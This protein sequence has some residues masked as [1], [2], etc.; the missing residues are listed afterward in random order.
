[1]EKTKIIEIFRNKFLTDKLDEDEIIYAITVE[2][3]QR[4]AKQKMGRLLDYT[5]IYSVKKGIEW[6]LDNW[7]EIIKV[8]I[9]NLPSRELE[10]DI[11]ENDDHI[12][13]EEE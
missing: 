2:D 1:M 4:I 10:E 12:K 13:K 8:A 6:G 9:G 5:E 3:V 7:D 11:D